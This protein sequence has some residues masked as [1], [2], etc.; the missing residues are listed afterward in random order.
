MEATE[1]GNGTL[2]QGTILNV[3]D[4]AL[5]LGIT[6]DI[7]NTEMAAARILEAVE[8]AVEEQR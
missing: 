4:L 6:E 8:I 1:L 7:M 3:W 5:S 2:T